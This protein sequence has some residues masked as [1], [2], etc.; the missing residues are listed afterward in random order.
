[1]RWMENIIEK[2]PLGVIDALSAGFELVLRHPWV[3]MVPIILDLFLWLGPQIR[4]KPVFEQMIGLLLNAA[5]Q[6][7]PTDNQQTMEALK[8]ALQ[9][10]GDQFNVFSFVAL[11]GM[12][13]PTL[14]GSDVPVAGGTRPFV[15]FSIGDATT[16]M[17]WMIA[18]AFLG[19]LLGTVYLELIARV[20]RRETGL[21]TL[22]P[23]LAKSY[24]NI[25]ALAI[26]VF[27][28]AFILTIPFL[29]SA[30]VV[31][32]FSQGLGSFF[33]LAGWLILLWMGLYLAF[34]IPSIF[35][36][37]V[38]VKQAILNSIA[39]FRYNFWSAMGLIFL[40]VLLETG[41]SVIWQTL[42]DNSSSLVVGMLANAIL[43]TAMI[44]AG[45]L[46]YNDRFTWLTEVRQRIRQQQRPSIKG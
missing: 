5:A 44:A 22:I 33:L 38:N 43:G 10:A 25:V 2:K 7:A 17:M 42:L 21:R 6:G 11:F 29:F 45:M 14:M 19:I 35:V 26:V 46:F 1:M 23:R 40:V 18:F 41:F 31:G 15:L 39:I 12:G 37:G 20:V 3:L 32:L 16:L 27:L 13:I 8:G 36:S 28:A 24:A 34:A 9:A 30:M 4:A